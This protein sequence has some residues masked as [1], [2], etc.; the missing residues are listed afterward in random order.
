MF[1]D[2]GYHHHQHADTLLT[3]YKRDDLILP[4]ISQANWKGLEPNRFPSN[5][6]HLP[7]PIV[8]NPEGHHIE[9]RHYNSI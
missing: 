6:R 9:R 7:A 4:F 3:S 5:K 1:N 8:S 2:S